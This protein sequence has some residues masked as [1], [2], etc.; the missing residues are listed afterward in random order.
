MSDLVYSEYRT[1]TEKRDGDIAK[2]LAL[3]AIKPIEHTS[4]ARESFQDL[5]P[6]AD[7]MRS[8]TEAVTQYKF[9]TRDTSP[10]EL[11]AMRLD[12]QLLQRIRDLGL[13]RGFTDQVRHVRQQECRIR[14]VEI[15]EC[16]TQICVE[17]T[18]GV[19]IS[20]YQ[21]IVGTPDT[22]ADETP[23]T[24]GSVTNNW[25]TYGVTYPSFQCIDSVNQI[26]R[27]LHTEGVI[28]LRASLEITR[29][30]RLLGIGINI[31]GTGSAYATGVSTKK[32]AFVGLY[33]DLRIQ[34]A[35]RNLPTGKVVIR[36]SRTEYERTAVNDNVW[37]ERATPLRPRFDLDVNVRQYDRLYFEYDLHW[38][39]ER[40]PWP[41]T[42]ACYSLGLTFV[43]IVIFESCDWQ[44]QEVQ[45]FLEML[46]KEAAVPRGSRLG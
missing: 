37:W 39:L 16:L 14:Q 21:Y 41:G 46:P 25:G 34:S 4:A 33:S 31:E 5:R 23:M 11:G 6:T 40:Y 28:S 7:E 36:Q 38:I 44:W 43:P 45:D 22:N 15:K 35:Y 29:F 18:E 3:S 32:D 20:E 26:N 17:Q 19:P 30:A 9:A 27:Q 42:I 2:P 1:V 10:D 12:E 13:S 24:I 8:R